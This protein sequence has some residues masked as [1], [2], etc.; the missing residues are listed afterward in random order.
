MTQTL[1]ACLLL[2]IQT[3]FW[4]PKEIQGYTLFFLFLLKT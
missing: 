2:L 3:W 4:S 1:L